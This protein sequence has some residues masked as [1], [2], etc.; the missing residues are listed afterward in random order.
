M[1]LE[2]FRILVV[3]DNADNLFLLQTVL[4][5]EGYKVDAAENRSLALAL[6][7]ASPPDLVLLDFMMPEMNGSDVTRRIR[8]YHKLPLI[9]MFESLIVYEL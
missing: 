8:N 4:E 9:L 2:S 3:D 6:I 7:E 1:L 5:A